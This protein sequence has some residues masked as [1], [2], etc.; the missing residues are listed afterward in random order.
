[1]KW[2]SE[3]FAPVMFADWLAVWA[4]A[5]LADVL[6]LAVCCCTDCCDCLI[7]C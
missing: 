4:A 1:M 5:V 6:V 3:K 7:A 2:C